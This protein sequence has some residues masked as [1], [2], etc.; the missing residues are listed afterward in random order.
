MPHTHTHISLVF[1]VLN[2]KHWAL[3][4]ASL[5]DHLVFCIKENVEVGRCGRNLVPAYEN[6][7]EIRHIIVVIHDP[8]RLPHLPPLSS[9]RLE[10][11]LTR[12]NSLRSFCTEPVKTTCLIQDLFGNGSILQPDLMKV[13]FQTNW[14]HPSTPSCL[15]PLV[16]KPAATQPK[17]LQCQMEIHG[18]N[19]GLA[20]QWNWVAI[21]GESQEE[22]VS[23]PTDN[24]LCDK[25]KA[26]MSRANLPT[27]AKQSKFS[28]ECIQSS[29]GQIFVARVPSVQRCSVVL[30]TP[31]K[32][33][34]VQLPF[35]PALV[36]SKSSF[37]AFKLK[38]F[39]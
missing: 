25:T 24:G 1:S 32:V 18:F 38:V 6:R 8:Q 31:P 35:Q 15:D 9:P 3:N 37:I 17:F 33:P 27:R 39:S 26:I 22:L 20:K 11:K 28:K 2:G 4:N 30:A 34:S 23:G 16:A 10:E 14:P 21:P 5:P 19:H 12:S 29:Q 13:L 36:S 7:I